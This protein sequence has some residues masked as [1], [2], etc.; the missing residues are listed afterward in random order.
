MAVTLKKADLEKV[1][2][3]LSE[4][5]EIID[6]L[7]V[8][9]TKGWNPSLSVCDDNDC[10]TATLSKGHA[11]AALHSQKGMIEVQLDGYGIKVES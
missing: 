9:S 5:G 3:L 10:K 8:I 6:C 2:S 1:Q 11:I 4:R 7:K